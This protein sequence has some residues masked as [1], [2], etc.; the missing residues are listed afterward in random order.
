MARNRLAGVAPTYGSVPNPTSAHSIHSTNTGN[1][2]APAPQQT[3]YP[4]P[5]NAVI[6]QAREPNP[7]AQ[8]QNPY[9]Q[10]NIAAAPG[11]GNY[12]SYAP[13]PVQNQAYGG[14][15]G[16][17]A[18]NPYAGQYG[19]QEGYATGGGAGVG[20]GGDFWAELSATQSN[21]SQLQEEIQAVRSAHQQS[22]VSDTLFSWRC[23]GVHSVGWNGSFQPLCS[24]AQALYAIGF[25]SK[26]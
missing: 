1:S 10:Q 24:Q 23:G 26:R 5:S 16:A 13:A 14:G 17:N 15:G 20:A 6:A 4:P 21:L 18:G 22:L 8:Q 19:Q 7:Y 25:T 9:A 2:D 11:V 12:N 3:F